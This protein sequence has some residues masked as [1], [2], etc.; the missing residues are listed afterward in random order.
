VIFTART[1]E[2]IRSNT[3]ADPDWLGRLVGW[4]R[5][6]G[7][8]AV[9]AKL[10]FPAGLIQQAGVVVGMGGQADH[11]YARR[12]A[13]HA[14][15]LARL[16]YL[17]EVGAVTGACLAVERAKFDAVGEFDAENLP[18][19]LNDI[20]L[21]LKSADRGWRST[22]VRSCAAMC[23]RSPASRRRAHADTL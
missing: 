8:G 14:G 12:P 6:P 7:I 16:P 13:V 4:A 20:D 23:S 9:G 5:D 2:R 18:V 15:Y 21:C 3:R 10:L 1:V 17:H 19:E 11:V 22:A